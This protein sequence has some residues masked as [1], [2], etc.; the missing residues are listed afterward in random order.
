LVRRKHRLAPY[1]K[2][3]KPRVSE[4]GDSVYVGKWKPGRLRIKNP[5]DRAVNLEKRKGV[6]KGKRKFGGSHYGSPSVKGNLTQAD[7]VENNQIY[8]D[9]S[10]K[11]YWFKQV[12][13][14]PARPDGAL[15]T[16]KVL[17]KQEFSIGDRWAQWQG[18]FVNDI[19]SEFIIKPLSRDTTKIVGYDKKDT[20]RHPKEGVGKMGYDFILIP[21]TAHTGTYASKS[22]QSGW[23][24]AIN[25]MINPGGKKDKSGMVLDPG[26]MVDFNKFDALTEDRKE[27]SKKSLNSNWS[28]LPNN[29][30]E[31]QQFP[32]HPNSLFNKVNV[33]KICRKNESYSSIGICTKCEGQ[34]KI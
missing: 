5:E 13:K 2:G 24:D 14:T 34:Q 31:V 1:K 15:S 29:A 20:D 18:D 17:Y 11:S 33:C 21:K 30:L 3:D 27:S 8:I 10:G 12:G 22:H 26:W 16:I 9:E 19:A 7:A 32:Y 28:R 25:S 6:H 4:N 23:S